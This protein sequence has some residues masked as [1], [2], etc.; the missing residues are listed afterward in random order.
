MSPFADTFYQIRMRYGIR[1]KELAQIMGFEQT[2]LSAIEVDKKGPPPNEFI[3]RF[4]QKLQLTE[5]EASQ[6]FDAAEASQRKFTLSKEL[7]QDVFWMMRDM[8]ARLP[9]L[10]TVQINLI[11]EILNLKDTLAQKPIETIR[12]IK[13]RRNKEAKM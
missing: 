9:E 6:L 5:L 8:R 10:S 1:Q 11:R 12:P 7:H 2:Y 4:I 13:R 3:Q